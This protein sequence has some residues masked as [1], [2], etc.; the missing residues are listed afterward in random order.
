MQCECSC[1]SA[2]SGGGNGLT[3]FDA[4]G[5]DRTCGVRGLGEGGG[6]VVPEFGCLKMLRKSDTYVVDSQVCFARTWYPSLW[7]SRQSPLL[8]K[9]NMAWRS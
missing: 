2:K 4:T 7:M 5:K 1:L 3:G 6:L 8:A 9:E